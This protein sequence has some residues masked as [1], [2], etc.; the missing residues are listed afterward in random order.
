MFPSHAS[1]EPAGKLVLDALQMKPFITCDMYLGE[2]TGA[3]AVLPI[4]QMA[5]NV[6]QKM[7]TFQ[8]IE[9]K[10]YKPFES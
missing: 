9:I 6:Y 2:G 4:L 5:V 8:E 1:K 3:I 10:E 7:S